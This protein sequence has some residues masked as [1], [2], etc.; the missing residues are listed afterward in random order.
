MK[1]FKQKLQNSNTNI[2]TF[3]SLASPMVSEIIAQV[4]F[5][6]VIVDL[7]HGIGNEKDTLAQLQAMESSPTASIVRVESHERL[8]V[9]R[10]LDIGAEG[11]MFPRLKTAVEAAEAISAMY[12]PPIGTRGVAKMV[13]IGG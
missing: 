1:N 9:N 12:Y 11:I 7:E 4:G 5:D 6:F 10:I 2:G 13:P 3:I 8:R